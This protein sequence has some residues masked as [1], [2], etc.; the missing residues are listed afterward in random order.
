MNKNELSSKLAAVMKDWGGE[1]E[2]R[3]IWN[4]QVLL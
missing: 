4:W 3:Q 2:G 1:D